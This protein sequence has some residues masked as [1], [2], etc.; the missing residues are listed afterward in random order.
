MFFMKRII[1]EQFEQ[2]QQLTQQALNE[3]DKHVGRFCK[4]ELR[5]LER[6]HDALYS[7]FM[8]KLMVTITCTGNLG[9]IWILM[10]LVLLASD[11]RRQYGYQMLIALLLCITI[12]NLIIKNIA[13]R[14]RP[15][16]HK[17]YKL[18]IKQPWDYSFP[19]GH[20][21]SSFAAATVLMYLNENVGVIAI[22]YACLIALSRLYLRVHFFTDVFFSMVLGT[23][24][25]ILA[26]RIFETRAFGLL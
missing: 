17:N 2:G 20:T 10:A 25:G 9:M 23:G 4:F 13:R 19:S 3:A 6:L 7:P 11:S 26:I 18:L 16:F 1:I 21:L 14:N 12:G 22:V 5:N 8:D 24:L 15:F